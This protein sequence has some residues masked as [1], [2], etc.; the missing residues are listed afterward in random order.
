MSSPELDMEVEET[1]SMGAVVR[2]SRVRQMLDRPRMLS[3]EYQPVVDIAR[4]RVW[5]YEVL[6]RLPGDEGPVAW[7]ASA[8]QEG[9]GHR[10]D[11][12]VLSRAID[13]LE[14]LPEERCLSVNVGVDTLLHASL[15]GT[16]ELAGDQAYRLVLE[17]TEQVGTADL[18]A[19]ADALDVVR[20]F[21]ARVALGDAAGGYA[22]LS[23]IGSLRPDI[24]KIDRR[25]VHGAH[26]DGVRAELVELVQLQAARQGAHV[27]AVGIEAI[28]DLR[29]LAASG[30]RYAQGYLLG[31][32]SPVLAEL[33][34][35]VVAMLEGID[36]LRV[37]SAGLVRQP[38]VVQAD[39]ED[40]DALDFDTDADLPTLVRVVVTPSKLPVALLIGSEERPRAV[41]VS[42][43][44]GLSWG[45][46]E[47]ARAAAT[48]DAE[49]RYDPVVVV[50][51]HG[52]L[53]GVLTV[54]DLLVHLANELDG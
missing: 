27:V 2:A 49:H 15:P 28:E 52:H 51:D 23:G 46:T 8:H 36:S 47:V 30:V 10:L 40:V 7:F 14:A 11:L 48:R 42:L 19:V 26:A 29:L 53:E 24:V 41:P 9:L 37:A 54:A 33:D 12:L 16:L 6:A 4:R 13:R 21:G 17:I 44:V 31:R 43:K 25:V 5:G 18:P 39:G 3:L 45:I 35:S 50:D 1:P 34:P 22:G 20:G 38:D 32:P